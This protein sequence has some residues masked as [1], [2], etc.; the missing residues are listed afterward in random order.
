MELLQVPLQKDLQQFLV[1]YNR[2]FNCREYFSADPY[3]SFPLL[4]LLAHQRGIA[5]KLLE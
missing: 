2:S 1:L 4:L 5:Q 3:R